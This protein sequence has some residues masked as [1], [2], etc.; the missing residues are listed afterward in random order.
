MVTRHKKSSVIFHYHYCRHCL[1]TFPSKGNLPVQLKITACKDITWSSPACLVTFPSSNWNWPTGIILK[2]QNQHV[3]FIRKFVDI[4][5]RRKR[6]WTE[7]NPMKETRICA[8][9]NSSV[10]EAPV[11]IPARPSGVSGFPIKG[12]RPQAAH[13]VAS[14]SQ[15]RALSPPRVKIL[16]YLNNFLQDTITRHWPQ[17]I[18]YPPH[19]PI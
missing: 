5:R 1:K 13:C 2:K 7:W 16:V 8:H 15:R 6:G 4:N 3:G 14:K 9:V 10:Y 11:Q 18:K 12:N 17:F 19:Q